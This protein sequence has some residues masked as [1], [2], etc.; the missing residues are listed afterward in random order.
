MS[1]TEPTHQFEADLEPDTLMPRIRFNFDNGWSASMIIQTRRN[2][3]I[4]QMANLA[5]CPAGQWG[6]AA[7]E[8]GP[9]EAFADEAVAW[10]DAVR[11]RP[12]IH[13]EQAA[14]A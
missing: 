12:S 13:A 8:L 7:T 9:S 2:G 5:C 6:S 11:Q 14:A 10:L 3:C 1:T 4:A